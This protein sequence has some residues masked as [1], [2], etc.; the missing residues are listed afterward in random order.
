MIL[1]ECNE[2]EL[3]ILRKY[4]TDARLGCLQLFFWSP[5]KVGAD[6][7]STLGLHLFL[8]TLACLMQ[9]WA[10]GVANAHCGYS[11]AVSMA[12]WMVLQLDWR[13]RE[14]WAG[15]PLPISHSTPQRNR[16][17]LTLEWFDLEVQFRCSML[18]EG[19]RFWLWQKGHCK[20]LVL[21]LVEYRYTCLISLQ[22]TTVLMIC[23]AWSHLL[24]LYRLG[25]VPGGKLVHFSNEIRRWCIHNVYLCIWRWP[26]ADNND[27]LP[28][29]FLSVLCQRTLYWSH[30]MRLDA[31]IR[32]L[33]MKLMSW[34]YT[35]VL[36]YTNIKAE[37]HRC[38]EPWQVCNNKI[39]LLGYPFIESFWS[40]WEQSWPLDP[41]WQ[42][43]ISTISGMASIYCL[44]TSRSRIPINF[45]S[46]CS[47]P[48]GMPW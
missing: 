17:N 31:W 45:C 16:C 4:L 9:S 28:M 2:H 10:I 23:K 30:C 3:C 1:C 37:H 36:G 21:N 22:L 35:T 25:R 32:M 14:E 15:R 42:I 47:K 8:M 39:A 44:Q 18:S 48:S 27:Y 29:L 11:I 43:L 38:P 46:L 24:A 20:M 41:S 5:S 33:L 7:C 12:Q 26:W 40:L 13:S 6:S 19:A 34:A